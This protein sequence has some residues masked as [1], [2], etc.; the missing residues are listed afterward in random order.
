MRIDRPSGTTWHVT[1]V[2]TKLARRAGLPGARVF[3]LV[4]Q[5]LQAAKALGLGAGDRFALALPASWMVNSPAVSTVL[6][7]W[8]LPPHR[9][10]CLALIELLESG[11]EGWDADPGTGEALRLAL[12]SLGNEPY[13]VEAISKVLALV[14]PATVPL[15]PPLAR[16]FVLGEASKDAP[17]AFE[18]MVQWF[19][20]AVRANEAELARLASLHREVA[21]T[22]AG[23]LDRVLWYD[24]DGV[25]HFEKDKGAAAP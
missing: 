2:E 22:P 10:A 11:P 12:A 7:R 13:V 24:S 21:L 14:V 17:D 6:R 19:A 8:A 16:A 18:R 20:G 4:G 15:M 3:D 23:V 5:S 9:E 1:E 25:R